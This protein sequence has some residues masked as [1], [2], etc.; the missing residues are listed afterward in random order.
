MEPLGAELLEPVPGVGVLVLVGDAG[1]LEASDI[2]DSVR[3]AGEGRRALVVDLARFRTADPAIAEI[4]LDAARAARVDRRSLHVVLPASS[5]LAG[6][7][8][9]SGLGAPLD[10]HEGRDSAV[11]AATAEAR[12]TAPDDC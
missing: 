10:L 8:R 4:L 12:R 1:P 6:V 7:L 3:I 5:P 2:A 9:T 11:R